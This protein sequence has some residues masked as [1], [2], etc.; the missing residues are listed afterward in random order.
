[1]DHSS[2]TRLT[3]RELTPVMLHGA[4][5]Y[6]ADDRKVGKVSHV[7]GAGP[8][9]EVVIKVGGFLGIGAKPVALPLSD[10]EFMRDNAGDVHAVAKWTKESL[11]KLPAHTHAH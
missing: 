2:H 9:A 6:D 8:T 4:T 11:E 10:L 1:M 5:V 7:H 3:A